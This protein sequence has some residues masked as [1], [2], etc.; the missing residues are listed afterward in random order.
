MATDPRTGLG[1]PEA[2]LAAVRVAVERAKC[3]NLSRLVVL[4]DGTGVSLQR[5]AWV[6]EGLRR[7]GRRELAHELLTTKL[8]ADDVAV[9]V[10][11]PR[12]EPRLERVGVDLPG[13]R[14]RPA[15]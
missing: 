9:L 3:A 2:T 13:V 7:R 15:P 12:E 6:C 14:R 4:V 5:R 10:V 8:E 11:V 1:L